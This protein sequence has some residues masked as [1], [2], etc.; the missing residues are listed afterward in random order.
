[1]DAD[2]HLEIAPTTFVA[3]WW[4]VAALLATTVVLQ[5]LWLGRYDVTGH[6]AG[7]LAS[8]AAA[9]PMAFF[10]AV[11]VWALPGPARRDPWLWI[12]LVAIAVG[13]LAMAAAHAD[14][15]DAIGS[16]D[17]TDAEAAAL[18]PARP[19][20]ESGHQLSERGALG[21]VAA[22]IGLAVVLWRRGRVSGRVAVGA[23]VLSVVFPYWVFPGLGVVVLA[24]SLAR[25][26]ARAALQP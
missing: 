20:F 13:V 14:V 24:V 17:W 19:G 11:L 12:V 18:G 23:A 1:M 5:I 16:D 6:A 2:V 8:A 21:S 26:R 4:P 15:V 22:T 10:V 7:H 3:R 25:G 9:F